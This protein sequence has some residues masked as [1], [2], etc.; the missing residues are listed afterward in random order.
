MSQWWF[1]L[2]HQRVEGDDGC[3]NSE[4]LGPFD[5]SEEAGRALEAAQ[6]RNEQWDAEEDEWQG[7]T[8]PGGE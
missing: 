6:R 2:V 3:A 8:A 7:R 1:C 4:R 5:T